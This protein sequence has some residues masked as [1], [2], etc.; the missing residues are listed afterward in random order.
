[1]GKGATTGIEMLISQVFEIG[2]AVLLG[3][4]RRRSASILLKIVDRFSARLA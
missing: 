2:G 3:K 4:Q 1:M